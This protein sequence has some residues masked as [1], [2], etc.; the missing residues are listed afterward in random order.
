V[1]YRLRSGNGSWLHVES[2]ATNLLLDPTVGGLVLNT[3]DITER[4]EV[5]EAIR[6]LQVERG[7]LL[8]RTVQATEQERKRI[9][10]EL[11]DG[12]VQRLTALDLKL[13]WIGGEVQQGGTEVDDRLQEVQS[14]LREQVRQLRQMMTQLRPPILDERGL[15]AALRDHLITS[16]NGVD[17]QVSVEAS[18]LKRLAPAQEIILYR[19]AQ[20]AVANVLKHARAEHAWLTL[21]ERNGQVLLEIRDDGIG[22]DPLMIPQSRNGHFGILGMRERVEMAGGSWELHSMPGGGTLVR[23]SLPRE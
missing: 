13:T 2:A 20:E 15:E 18:L 22:F 9:A 4:H 10:V 8:D 21:Q 3:R 1:E 17:L 5:E 19:V 11:H 23:A 16:D 7:Q 14:L 12:P 6:K